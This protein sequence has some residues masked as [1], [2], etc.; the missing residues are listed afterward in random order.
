HQV[1]VPLELCAGDVAAWNAMA[2]HA[3][4]PGPRSPRISKSGVVQKPRPNHPYSRAKIREDTGISERTQIRHQEMLLP[5]TQRKVTPKRA[6]Y[7]TYREELK[8]KRH[9]YWGQKRLGNSYSSNL[10]RRGWGQG[11]AFNKE[12]S[13]SRPHARDANGSSCTGRARRFF[14]K[15]KDFL[16][17]REKDRPL[18]PDAMLRISPGSREAPVVVGGRSYFGWWEVLDLA[19]TAVA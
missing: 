15:A 1:E 5:G 2:Y 3:W 10:P 8:S 16:H 12:Q 19:G 11:K 14:E 18:Y 6:N 7:A 13:G 9:C 17:A 4:L